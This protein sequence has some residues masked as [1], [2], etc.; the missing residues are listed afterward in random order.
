MAKKGKTKKKTTRRNRTVIKQAKRVVVLNRAKKAKRNPKIAKGKTALRRTGKAL[1]GAARSLL[2]AGSEI[3]G[4]GASA[5]N[6]S[7]KRIKVRNKYVDLIIRGQAKKTPQGWQIGGKTITQGRGTVPLS[8]RGFYLDRSTGFVYAKRER[9][10]APAR[11]KKKVTTKKR[12]SVTA[13]SPRKSGRSRRPNPS[14]EEIRKSFAGSVS[15]HR[16]LYFPTGTPRGL[17]KLGKVVSITT[18]EGTLKPVHG[19]AWL[20][21]DTAGKLHLGSTRASPLV[22]GPARNFGKVSKIEYEERKPH[23]GYG[24]NPV[25]WFHRMGEEGGSRPTLRADG[26]GGLMFRGGSYKITS[27][28]IEN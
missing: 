14:P 4:A 9:N 1:K 20:C 13:R 27:R 2:S 10:V 15:G 19:T 21:A 26:K 3:L 16:E 8:K 25:I 6:P 23:L 22:N 12:K 11:S 24:K 5:L 7:R 18:E 17:A 28:G